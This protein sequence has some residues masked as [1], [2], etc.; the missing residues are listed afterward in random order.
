M[1]QHLHG[2]LKL[3]FKKRN[4]MISKV[5]RRIKKK[6]KFG[7]VIPTNYEEAILIDRANGNRFWQDA[8]KKEMS[9][10]E[11]AFKFLDDE[12]KAPIG[13]KEITCHLIFDVKFDLT[14]KARYVGGGHLTSVSPSMSYSSV[15]SRDSVRIMFLIAAL[16]DLD[17][18]MCDIGNAY[19]NA[20]TRERVWFTVGSEWSKS[21]EGCQVIIVRALYGLKSSGAEWKKTFAN[22][23]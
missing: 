4:I 18:E 13:F 8:V 7:I 6:M 10:V 16:N 5:A 20:E 17:I 2:G 19:L 23:I 3:R 14:R 9:N 11:I 1:S 22:Y 15:V 21:R 12:T